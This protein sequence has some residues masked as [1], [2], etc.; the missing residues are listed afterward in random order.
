MD[1][2]KRQGGGI[3]DEAG[4]REVWIT[5]IPHHFMRIPFHRRL[6]CNIAALIMSG[7]ERIMMLLST[8]S[9]WGRVGEIVLRPRG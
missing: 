1:A 4:R 3:L 2:Q 5:S 9:K 7:K 6:S 8:W